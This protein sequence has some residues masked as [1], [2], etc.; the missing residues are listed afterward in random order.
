MRLHAYFQTETDKGFMV[1][2]IIILVVPPFVTTVK[3]HFCFRQ[4]KTTLISKMT[5]CIK[6][7]I[8]MEDKCALNLDKYHLQVI[9]FFSC[10]SYLTT[11]QLTMTKLLSIKFSWFHIFTF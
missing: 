4:K 10:P 11:S 5:L 3:W 7:A 6:A 8:N 2:I 1:K 9:F